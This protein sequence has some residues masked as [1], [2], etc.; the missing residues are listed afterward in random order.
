MVVVNQKN[1]KYKSLTGIFN[2]KNITDNYDQY[3]TIV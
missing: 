1:K 2:D 3:S